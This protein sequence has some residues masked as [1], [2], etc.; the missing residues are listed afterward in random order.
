MRGEERCFH[1]LP[2]RAS[3]LSLPPFLGI[4]PL[5]SWSL[6]PPT[7][8]AHTLEA[9]WGAGK[10]T[11]GLK[12]PSPRL[13]PRAQPLLSLTSAP[14]PS[15]PPWTPASYGM[16]TGNLI[17]KD[18]RMIGVIWSTLKTQ[19][20]KQNERGDEACPRT[21]TGEGGG[22]GGE[23]LAYW[24]PEPDQT[25]PPL[26]RQGLGTALAPPRRDQQDHSLKHC[27]HLPELVPAT[28]SLVYCLMFLKHISVQRFC[29]SKYLIIVS[30]SI[31]PM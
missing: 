30:D 9:F 31:P 18:H 8:Y 17:F 20:K 29:H 24:S 15:S 2:L 26:Q 4:C 21:H 3:L 12:T 7:P 1:L 19:Q 23:I 16:T 28:P 27:L 13:W 6:A 10:I 25:L 5:Q 22:W 11:G 14:L